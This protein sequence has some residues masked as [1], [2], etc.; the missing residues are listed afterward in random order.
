MS[1]KE[2]DALRFKMEIIRTVCPSLIL[3]IN[4]FLLMDILS[5]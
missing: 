5:K 3:L 4:L 1:K 2:L